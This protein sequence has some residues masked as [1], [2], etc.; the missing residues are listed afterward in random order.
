MNKLILFN[1]EWNC[2]NGF[3]LE[4]FSLDIYKPI[5]M[6]RSLFAIYFSKRFLYIHILFIKCIFFDLNKD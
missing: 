6:E 2:Y 3:M 1:T 4:L 5:N